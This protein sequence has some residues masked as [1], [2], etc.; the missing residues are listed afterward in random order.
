M[1]P[2]VTIEQVFSAQDIAARIAELG[3]EIRQAAG[4]DDVFLL[5]I[6]KGTACFAS[7]LL[8]A[9]PG[10]VSYGFIDVIRDEND[11]ETA[12]ALEIDFLS[13]TEIGNRNVFLLKDV[14]STGAIEGYLLSQLRMHDPR[15]LKL[16]AMLDRPTLRTSDTRADFRL[17]EAGE[18]AYVGYGL[19]YENRFGNLPFIGRV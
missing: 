10:N 11:T 15:S 8:R 9:I 4:D 13:Y 3:R 2:P 14:V 17:F 6:L 16:V 12:N 19:E 7:D 1:N 5:G 18:G